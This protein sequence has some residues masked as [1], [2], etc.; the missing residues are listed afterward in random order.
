M[1]IP[2]GTIDPRRQTMNKVIFTK[3]KGALQNLP[4]QTP[5]L[6]RLA[7]LCLAFSLCVS[8]R[9]AQAGIEDI[10]EIA[11]GPTRPQ[12]LKAA[13]EE[14]WKLNPNEKVLAVLD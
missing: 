6:T 9:P 13:L 3:M 14:V 10:L 5:N 12:S 4:P 8:S 7:L 11:Q 2:T 1:N